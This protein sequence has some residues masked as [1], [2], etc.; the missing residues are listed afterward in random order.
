L[1]TGVQDTLVGKEIA[2]GNE[3]IIISRYNKAF[4]TP[5]DKNTVTPAK[6]EDIEEESRPV[7]T[8]VEE[9]PKFPGGETALIRFLSGNITYPKQ[10][11]EREIQGTIYVSFIVNSDGKVTDGKI[12]RG[13]GGG[14]EKEALRVVKMMPRWTPGKQDGKPVDVLYT[15]PIVFRLT[16]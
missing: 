2:Q 4:L 12:L 5:N 6:N 10:A 15:M 13:I 7:F 11:I 14:C 9:M 1:A 3:A 8:M 16:N